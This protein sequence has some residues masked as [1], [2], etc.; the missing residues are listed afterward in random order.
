MKSLIFFGWLRPWRESE[1]DEVMSCGVFFNFLFQLQK[2]FSDE[3]K[4]LW[5]GNLVVAS[6]LD[7]P[8]ATG[9]GFQF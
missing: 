2:K 4:S 5:F 7:K 8:A 9:T 3:G 1:E 6:K